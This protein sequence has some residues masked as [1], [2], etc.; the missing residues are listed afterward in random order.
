MM[1]RIILSICIPFLIANFIQAQISENMSLLG[2][3]KDDTL[4]SRYGAVYNDVWGFVHGER[5]YAIMGSARYTHFVDVTDPENL[6]EVA[7]FKEHSLSLWRDYKTYGFY[8]YG[9]AQESVPWNPSGM[10]IFYHGDLPDSI[11]KVYD[12]N[13][14]FTTAHNIFIDE[15]NGRLYVA[16]SNVQNNG[17]LVLDLTADPA[18]PSLLASVPLPGGYVHDVYVRNNI[19]YCSHGNSGLYIYDFTNPANPALIGNLTLYP[20]QGYNHSSW[21]TDDGN[22]LVFADETHGRPLR[23]VDVTDLSDITIL[24]TF[25]SNLLAPIATNSIPHNPIIRGDYVFISYYHDGIQVYD[26]SDVIAPQRVAYYD[27]DTL[28]TDYAGYEGAW[29]VYPLLP[30]HNILGSDQLNGLFVLNFDLLNPIVPQPLQLSADI[31]PET[32]VTKPEKPT[33][34]KGS[35]VLAP[36]EVNLY[37]NPAPKDKNVN[38][39]IANNFQN[40]A[41]IRIYDL[42]GRIIWEEK[43]AISEAKNVVIPRLKSGIYNVSIHTE[44]QYVNQK[45]VVED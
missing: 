19:T 35:P 7:R 41:T 45:L 17:L 14:L 5:E 25:Q 18:N 27:T 31:S 39:Q 8:S 1:R 33:K 36:L 44:K 12:D 43:T 10:Q 9:M 30:S 3:W 32:V 38:L 2:Q 28:F 11:T 21:L 26:I 22:F 29:G 34:E 42:A 16:G 15:P 24:S 23:L 37:P 13:A 20:Q 40:E 4:P 6:E